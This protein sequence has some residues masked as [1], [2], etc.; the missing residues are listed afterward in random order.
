MSTAF[1]CPTESEFPVGKMIHTGFICIVHRFISV[2]VV[3]QLV[4]KITR[5]YQCIVS[6]NRTKH[7]FSDLVT[8]TQNSLHKE[9]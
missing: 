7:T 8:D 2:A 9:M 1:I 5:N 6:D 3:R 4:M